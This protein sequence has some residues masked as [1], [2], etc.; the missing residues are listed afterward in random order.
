MKK[1]KK[2]NLLIGILIAITALYVLIMYN[3]MPDQIPTHWNINGEIDN[4]GP[5]STLYVFVLTMI[6]INLLLLVIKKIDPKS[7]NYE[8][9][10]NAFQVFRVAITVFFMVLVFAS[11]R[12]S[13]KPESFEMGELVP[14]MIGFLFLVIGNYM[15]KFKHNYTM[16]I[17]TPWT[18]ASE[19][20]WDSTHRFAGP[21]WVVG[22]LLFILSPFIINDSMSLY[23]YGFIMVLI[24]IVPTVYSY[25]VFKNEKH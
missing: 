6:G 10:D 8:R 25:V 11:I 9:F 17:K 7:A 18:L 16:G 4:Y 23:L 5:R 1:N 3:K 14:V 19:T 12:I 13:L 24:V 22:G 21:L 15:P 2:I 20:C